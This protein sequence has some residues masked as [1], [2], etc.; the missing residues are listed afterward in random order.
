[1]AAVI[2]SAELASLHELDSVYS[3]EDACDL[4]ELALVN[5]NNRRVLSEHHAQEAKSKNKQRA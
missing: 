5:A 4:Y 3:Y 2:I 1:M